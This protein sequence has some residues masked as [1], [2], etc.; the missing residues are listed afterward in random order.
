MLKNGQSFGTFQEFEGIPTPNQ[1]NEFQE[2]LEDA[3]MKSKT[4]FTGAH[5]VYGF[6]R[7]CETMSWLFQ[8]KYANLHHVVH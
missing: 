4:I 8:N 5:N 6:G 2:Y 3:H 1:W 7:Y